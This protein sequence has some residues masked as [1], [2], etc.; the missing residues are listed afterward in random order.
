[1][2]REPNRATRQVLARLQPIT[3]DPSDRA[4]HEQQGLRLR[5]QITDVSTFPLALWRRTLTRA[6]DDSRRQ[7]L[8]WG[9]AAG[10]HEL[11]EATARHLALT[12]GVRCDARQVLIVDSPL[13]AFH[14][15]ALVLLE[16]GSVAA[17]ADP[18]HVSPSRHYE[19]MHMRTL[20]LPVD[21]DG[22]DPA[23]LAAA[24]PAPAIVMVSPASQYPLGARLSAPR[25][26]ELLRWA[27]ASG[28]WIIEHG[29]A[30][31]IAFDHAQPAALAA[32]DA[33]E[34]VLLVG[35]FSSVMY[36]SL[37]LSYLVVPERL[38]ASFAAVRGL[39]GDHTAV[40]P[41]LAMAEFINDEHLAT[42]LRRLR[43]VY[44]ARRNALR[45]SLLRRPELGAGLV[46]SPAGLN[47][48]VQ[49]PPAA[50]DQGLVQRLLRRSV[51]PLAL[52]A[53]CRRAALN[54]LVLGFGAEEPAAID[55]AVTEIAR[56]IAERA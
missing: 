16:P 35:S 32:E 3:D 14:L 55:D 18:G 13:Q 27:H 52:S 33:H 54:G 38:A 20:P 10:T 48:C 43:T 45:Q 46:D 21:A 6:L 19:L 12:R 31:E 11:R 50:Q 23:A 22:I 44:T 1:V 26:E 49:L 28:A 8:S 41:Q 42:H 24:D 34:S 53:H 37:R 39:F 36:P 30:D 9:P 51:A 5:P 29:F 15:I 7:R 56:A 25:R 40:A 17:I 2:R 4:L 47:L